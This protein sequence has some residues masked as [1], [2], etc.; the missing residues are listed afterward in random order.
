MKTSVFLFLC[1]LLGAAL[2]ELRILYRKRRVPPILK[3]PKY[4]FII[5]LLNSLVGGAITLIVPATTYLGA[6][7]I[8]ANWPFFISGVVSKPLPDISKSSRSN[9][10]DKSEKE[11]EEFE[12]ISEKSRIGTRKGSLREYLGLLIYNPKK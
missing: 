7:Y 4:Y 3:F 6:L 2:P 11:I 9:G 5:L 8:G 1:G 12:F 10:G